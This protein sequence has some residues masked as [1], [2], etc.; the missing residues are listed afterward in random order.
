[1]SVTVRAPRPDEFRAA[2]AVSA[3]AL[4]F[5][6]A[7]DDDWPRSEPSWQACDSLVAV[8]DDRFVAHV[9]GFRFDSVVPGGALVPTSGVTRVGVLPTH[10]R[11]G[12]LSSMLRQL[13]IEARARGQVLAALRASEARIYQRFGFGVAGLAQVAEIDTTRSGGVV[14]RPSGGSVRLLERSE[15]L[16]VVPAV[17]RHCIGHRPGAVDRPAWMWERYLRTALPDSHDAAHVVVHRSAHGIDDGYC[18]YE[19]SWVEEFGREPVGRAEVNDLWGATPE[20][21]AALWAFVLSL[22]L[23]RHVRAEERPVDDVLPWLL[24]DRRAYAVREVYDEQWVRLLDV[25]AALSARTYGDGRPVSIELT[26]PWFPGH[27]G[28]WRITP[29]GA[30]RSTSASADL[31]VS[32]A[33]LSAA[34]LGG[35]SWHHLAATGRVGVHRAGALDD[36]D[37]LFTHRPAPFCGSFF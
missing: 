19:L 4:L 11:R 33:E 20:V 5:G 21:E 30:E 18:H 14:A 7:S 10:R 28:V 12:L 2:A 17:S 37:R 9:G 34:Y 27:D 23:V 16:D 8:D 1:M 24:A 26:D 29:D 31:S 13:L 35:T 15:I 6:P 22:D 32:I 3:T 36:A 25:G